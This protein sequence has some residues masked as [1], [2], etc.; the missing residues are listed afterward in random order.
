MSFRWIYAE[1]RVDFCLSFQW[2]IFHI[3]ILPLPSDQ[4]FSYINNDKK[5]TNY[6]SC[7]KYGTIWIDVL[8]ATLKTGDDG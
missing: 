3:Y 8:I 4:Y 5:Y 2:I 1:F 7:V 6:K